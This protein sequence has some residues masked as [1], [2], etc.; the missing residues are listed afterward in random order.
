[1]D[2]ARPTPE[3]VC[4]IAMWSGPR[5]IS[6]ALM[7]SWGARR[8][9]VVWD[10]PLYAHY[11][12]TTQ[13]RRHPGYDETLARHES[14][15]RVVV[16]TLMRPLPRDKSIQ[17][18]KQMAHHLLP[19]VGREWIDGIVNCLLIREP[20]AVLVSFAEFVPDPRPEDIG[21]P[22]QIELLDRTLERTGQ[23]PPVIDSADVLVDPASMLS[24]LCERIGAP[25]TDEMLSWPPG[26]RESDGA[27]APYWYEK[28]AHTTGFGPPRDEKA[29]V[30]APLRGVWE[31]CLP[32]YDRLAA[33]RITL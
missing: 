23:P 30:P 4:R 31:D 17:Y 19:G 16:E 21:L 13:D 5:N 33:V 32:L 29:E 18:Q 22:Q 20:A 15:W 7:R 2:S 6:T 25:Y 1:M 28:V 10:E 14:D 27:W 9:T 12:S 11:L 26:L 8:D 24:R 3:Q